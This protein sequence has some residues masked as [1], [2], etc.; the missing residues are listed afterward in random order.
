MD[1]LSDWMLGVLIYIGGLIVNLLLFFTLII[2]LS[3][4]QGR[5]NG[6]FEVLPAI[7]MSLLWPATWLGIFWKY[8][9]PSR[10]LKYI[11]HLLGGTL[12]SKTSLDWFN[13]LASK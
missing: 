5:R 13:K 4:Y 11:W 3:I 2:R 7:V 12:G 9:I 8:P 10:S 1:F 6:V